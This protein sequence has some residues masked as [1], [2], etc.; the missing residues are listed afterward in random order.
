MILFHKNLYFD[1]EGWFLSDASSSNFK[2][3][4][5]HIDFL[6]KSF[7]YRQKKISLHT[8]A[9][10]R[11][12]GIKKGLSLSVVDATAGL[13]RD[14]FI[15][16]WLGCNVCMIERHPALA[17]LLQDA[18]YRYKAS[19][20]RE[21]LLSSLFIDAKAY[22]NSCAMSVDVVYLDPMYPLRNKKALPQGEI[23]VVR[24]LIGEDKDS[25]ELFK[26][27]LKIAQ[28][29]VV[30][31]RPKNAPYLDKVVPS[32]S[33]NAQKQHRFDVYMVRH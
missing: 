11:A 5:L 18:I 14:G 8:E 32:F 15:L 24:K 23:Q 13:G 12:I 26:I 9:I 33:L 28:K 16:A 30:I 7:V 1:K 3:K 21:L 6:S 22:L 29:R 2:K 27:A 25:V 19:E 10:G 4:P 17:L 20:S 31:K